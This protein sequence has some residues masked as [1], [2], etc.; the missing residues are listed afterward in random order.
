MVLDVLELNLFCNFIVGLM[1]PSLFF[2]G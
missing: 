2:G 1:D